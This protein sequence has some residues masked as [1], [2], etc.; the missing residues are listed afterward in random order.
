MFFCS[1]AHILLEQIDQDHIAALKQ[2]QI[3]AEMKQIEEFSTSDEDFG[4]ECSDS[5]QVQ[6]ED[7]NVSSKF[8]LWGKS[9]NNNHV[10]GKKRWKNKQANA[11]MKPL[12]DK[13]D[14]TQEEKVLL[15]N[16]FTSFMFSNFLQGKDE[17]N[18]R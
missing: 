6:K 10:I 16:E 12:K 9:Y 14:L 1:I 4:V 17:F 18:Y 7:A 13:N 8:T 3:E 5:L 11:K 15:I 2:S